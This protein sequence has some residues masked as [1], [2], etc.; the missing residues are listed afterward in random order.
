MVLQELH[1]IQDDRCISTTP[2]STAKAWFVPKGQ[3]IGTLGDDG[4]G[5][6][7]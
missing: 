6:F 3:L 2:T 1:V 7:G 5:K 4:C